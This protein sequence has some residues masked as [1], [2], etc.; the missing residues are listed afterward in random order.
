MPGALSL[1][2]L[3]ACP[4]V[5]SSEMIEMG[6]WK[7]ISDTEGWLRLRAI[8]CHATQSTLSYTSNQEGRAGTVKFEQFR[9]PWRHVEMLQ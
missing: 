5:T 9:Q 8:L 3:D 1:P 2:Y 6:P 4:G 7:E